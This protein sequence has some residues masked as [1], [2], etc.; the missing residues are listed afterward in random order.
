MQSGAFAPSDQR[1]ADAVGCPRAF[2]PEVSGA[3]VCSRGAF[4]REA[5]WY[6][7]V[8]SRLRTGGLQVHSDAPAT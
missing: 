1:L 3:V 6:S 8:S 7:R 4:G 2:G 5:L